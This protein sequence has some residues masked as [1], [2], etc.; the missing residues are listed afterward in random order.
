MFVAYFSEARS[1]LGEYDRS[2][3]KQCWRLGGTRLGQELRQDAQQQR[4]ESGRLVG[5]GDKARY[6]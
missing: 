2:I 4:R 1:Y 5:V 3:V 6:V